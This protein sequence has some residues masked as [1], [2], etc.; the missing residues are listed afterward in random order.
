MSILK[1]EHEGLRS[2]LELESDLERAAEIRYGR[3][4]E[5]ERQV[6]SA[7]EALD[8]LQGGARMLKEEVDA[9]D[10]AEIVAK[11]TGVPVS[12]LMEGEMAKLVRLEDVL[13]E[14][15]I[16]QEEAGAAVAAATRGSPAGPPN[17]KGD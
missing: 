7:T 11:W 5:L 10:V 16:G 17:R 14:G 12:R 2:D 9:E 4:P 15:V 1:E 8:G 3:I 13:H 6:Q